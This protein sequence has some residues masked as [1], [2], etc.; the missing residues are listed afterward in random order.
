VRK[1]CIHVC[2]PVVGHSTQQKASL[3]DPAAASMLTPVAALPSSGLL[4]R[5]T[6]LPTSATHSRA[7]RV[8][9]LA[10]YVALTVTPA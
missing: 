7:P 1:G 3:Q 4:L 10:Q 9:A 2:V 8:T 5:P 6:A